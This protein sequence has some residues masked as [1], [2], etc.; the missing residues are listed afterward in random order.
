MTSEVFDC[1]EAWFPVFYERDL[2]K[3]H[4]Q[5]FVLLGVPIVIWWDGQWNAFTDRCPHRLASLSEGRINEQ[6]N[7]ECPYHGWSFHRSGQCV[8]IPQQLP[9][10]D[11]HTSVRACATV[12]A[13][14]VK[15]GLLFV[16]GK[17]GVDADPGLIPIVPAMEEMDQDWVCIDTFRD[18]PYDAFTLLENVLDSSHLPYTHHGSVG[19]RSNAAPVELEVLESGRSGFVGFW[20]EGPRRGKLGSQT[21]KFVAPNLM[22]HD[23]TSAQFGRTLTVVYA[24]PIEK[25][26]CRVFAR[27]PFKFPSAFPRLVFRLTPRWLSHLGQNAILEDDQIFLHDQERYFE[28]L[29][30]SS[31]V[32][33]AFYL[34]TKAD[35]F[36]LEFHKWIDRYGVDPFPGQ[37]LP[38][39]LT[40][41]QLLDRYNSHTIHCASCRGAL[42]NIDRIRLVCL[43]LIVLSLLVEIIFSIKIATITIGLLSF[44]LWLSLGKLRT[45]FYKGREIPPR[46]LDNRKTVTPPKLEQKSSA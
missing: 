42:Q 20:A 10:G 1:R 3:L 15:Q 19:N 12:H 33:R 32:S 37:S 4:P 24:T 14:A 21:T 40:K 18:L 28:A 2:D 35:L 25:G 23:L 5:K 46:N 27:F 39:R 7:L 6:G 11:A 29:G 8:H 13:T 16:Y 41:E 38:P 22:W 45:K 34:P 26:K 31:E 44:V 17:P 43:S 36:V 9:G 30:G